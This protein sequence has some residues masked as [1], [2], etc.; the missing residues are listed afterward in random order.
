MVASSTFW[1][2][3]QW[4]DVRCEA[5]DLEPNI[6]NGYTATHE[7]I[8]YFETVE[9]SAPAAEYCWTLDIYGYND[10][11]LPLA[12]EMYDALNELESKGELSIEMKNTPVWSSRNDTSS[13]SCRAYYAYWNGNQNINYRS[14]DEEGYVMPMRNF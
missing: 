13:E 6:D 11:Y 3:K 14:R 9:A 10:W 1:I 8:E 4:S 12:D 2:L 5:Q 7:I